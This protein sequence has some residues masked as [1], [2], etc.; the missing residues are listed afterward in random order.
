[1]CNIA[2]LATNNV[3]QISRA[4]FKTTGNRKKKANMHI[5]S[6]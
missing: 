1:M 5:Y 2:R 4:A 6:I 3:K